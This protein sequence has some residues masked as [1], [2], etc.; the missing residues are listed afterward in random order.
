MKSGSM[1]LKSWYAFGLR[2][3]FQKITEKVANSLSDDS[4]GFHCPL[5]YQ[6]EEGIA[7]IGDSVWQ[8]ANPSMAS[9]I[10]RNTSVHLI[11]TVGM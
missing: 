11:R 10:F 1:I 8:I 3:V 9:K 6:I 4:R 5:V 2:L 7:E